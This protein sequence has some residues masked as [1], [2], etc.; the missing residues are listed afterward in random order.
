MTKEQLIL[1]G[2]LLMASYMAV[3]TLLGTLWLLGVL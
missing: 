2:L 1:T 3:G